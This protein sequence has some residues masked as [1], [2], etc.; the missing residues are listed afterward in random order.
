MKEFWYDISECPFCKN[1]IEH[2]KVSTTAEKVS[3]Y[4]QDLKPVYSG[5]NVLK[6]SIVTCPKCN[7]TFNINDM[8]IYEKY[9]S[10]FKTYREKIEVFLK[11]LDSKTIPVID[12]SERKSDFFYSQQLIINAEIMAI[13]ERPL[14]SAKALLKLSW[15]Y[16]ENGEENKELKILN[17]VLYLAE[18][19]FSKAETDAETIFALFYPGYIHYR[20]GRKKEA[21]SFFDKLRR[22]YGNSTNP[23]I[24]AAKTL[25][26]ELS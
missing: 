16:R 12:N 9:L 2:A 19:F 18:T 23:Y 7:F 24:K 3:K 13:F 4:D 26:S 22:M 14:D 1:H 10:S 17:D 21:A 6:F 15:L 5:P 8:K 11:S 20:F 25:R